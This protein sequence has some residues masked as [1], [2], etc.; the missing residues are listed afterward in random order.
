MSVEHDFDLDVSVKG[1]GAFDH[2]SGGWLPLM[3][4]FPITAHIKILLPL[5]A[6]SLSRLFVPSAKSCD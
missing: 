5:V 3:I 4:L 2:C 1:E 6:Q